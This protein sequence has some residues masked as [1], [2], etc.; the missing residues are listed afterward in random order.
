[1]NNLASYNWLKEYLRTDATAEEFARELSLK[2][3]SVESITDMTV[4]YDRMVIGLVKEIK[5]HPDADRLRVALVDI[6]SETVEIVCGGTNLDVGQRVCVALP[7]ARVERG[8]ESVTLEAAEIRGVKSN[9]MICAP[10][11]IGF[12]DLRAGAHTI[13]NLAN[14]VDAK[15]GTP[16][17]EAMGLNDVLF[18]VEITT[19][20]PDAMGRVGL[21]REAAAALGAEFI[22]TPPK[23]VE[24]GKQIPFSV[25]IEDKTRCLRQMAVVI[26]GVQ[27]KQ[28]PWWLQ[29]RLLTAG[30][31]PINN[32]VDI[33]NYVM[34]ELGQPLHTFDYDTLD[35]DEIRV[36]GGRPG[37]KIEAL[38]GKTYDVENILV[39]TDS[40][41]PLDIAGVMGGEGTGTKEKT[42]TIVL[43]A[44]AFDGTSIRRGSRALNVQS[45]AQMLFEKGLS[46]EA[47][48]IALVRAVELILQIAGGHIASPV[49]DERVVPY[50]P[51]VFPFSPEVARRKIGVDI[52]DDDM[53]HILDSL[54]FTSVKNGDRYD[55]TVPFWRD[56][57]IEASID[58]VEEVARVYGYH[59][60]PAVLPAGS[61]PMTSM[62]TSLVWESFTKYFLAER[63]Y[64]ELFSLSFVSEDD[65]RNIGEDPSRAY[66]VLNPLVSDQTHMRTSLLPSL[67]HAVEANSGH[68]PAAK[69]FELSRTYQWRAGDIPEERMALVFGEYGYDDA[70]AAFMGTKGAL[71]AFAEAANLQLKIERAAQVDDRWHATRSANIII[72]GVMMGRV[73]ELSS[74]LCGRFG[75]DRRVMICELDFEAL[76]PHMVRVRRYQP[77]PEFPSIVRDASILFDDRVEYGAVAAAVRSTSPMIVDA[78]LKEIY[79]GKGVEAGKKSVTLSVTMNAGRTM[80]SPEADEVMKKIAD[81]L[82]EQFGGILR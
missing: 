49:C 23:M 5:A 34:L 39:L 42:T 64:D 18:D 58:L 12:P 53:L 24:G 14:I 65:L 63:G 3:M 52:S 41:K 32:I 31:R 46:T 21:A 56:H 69:I 43:S 48:P 47:P 25:T 11:E 80:T 17:A 36:R 29:A 27:V 35:G 22:W 9:G 76:I 82:T 6:G 50:V 19:N 44:S 70:E 71:Q 20:R 68:T 38:N 40:K 7:G 73:G 74:D 57:D 66:R 75:V 59:N 33:T 72:G 2:S 8:G 15:A 51:L 28:S 62:D 78:A 37:E 55:V 81:V 60:M 30:V 77:V 1:M 10:E 54:G 13:W 79:R 67:L 4:K 45:D 26:D 61:P 16:F